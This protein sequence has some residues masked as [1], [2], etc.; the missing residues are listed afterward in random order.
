[1]SAS[2]ENWNG[3]GLNSHLQNPYGVEVRRNDWYNRG[4]MKNCL[5]DLSGCM[6]VEDHH[7]LV[8]LGHAENRHELP[9]LLSGQLLLQD[10]NLLIKK[11]K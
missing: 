11:K 3:K 6:V 5:W 1:M 2:L 4:C 7:E 10:L 9:P 8:H